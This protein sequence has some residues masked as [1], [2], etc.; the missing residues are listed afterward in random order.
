ME[1][2]ILFKQ[3][4]RSKEEETKQ[5]IRGR[6][7]KECREVPRIAVA[8]GSLEEDWYNCGKIVENGQ[9][10]PEEDICMG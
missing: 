8:V 10:D 7:E 6:S 1:N 9:T 2:I 5:K 4:G 3:D